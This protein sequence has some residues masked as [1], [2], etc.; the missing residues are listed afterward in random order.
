MPAKYEY[1]A[2]A[3]FIYQYCL[4]F[5]CSDDGELTWACCRLNP[6]VH[7]EVPTCTQGL[8]PCL[9]SPSERPV[10]C[11][12]HF[13][14]RLAEKGGSEFM[15][16]YRELLEALRAADPERVEPTMGFIKVRKK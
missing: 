3:A 13:C 10:A 2:L 4:R 12:M 16:R 1:E 15:K 5:G 8:S 7:K 6:E 9:M 14:D 11:T